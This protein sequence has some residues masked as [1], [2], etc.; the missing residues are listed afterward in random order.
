MTDNQLIALVI[1]NLNTAIQLA[2]WSFPVIQKNNP[3]QQGIPSTPGVFVEKAF[4]MNYGFAGADFALSPDQTVFNDSET[5]IVETTV[6]ISAWAIQDPTNT[7]APTASDICEYL[8]QYMNHRTI[9]AALTA[10]GVGVYRVTEVRNPYIT[11]DRTLFEATP[12]F[13][14][15]LVHDRT[16]T[17]TVPAADKILPE[18]GKGVYELGT[19][20]IG[21]VPI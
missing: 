11:D 15:V 4:D 9:A 18:N 20:P 19:I 13:D 10:L 6:Q 8:K 1:S 21:L 14:L 5:Q 3:T 12:S 16:L 7:S 2:G 17:L